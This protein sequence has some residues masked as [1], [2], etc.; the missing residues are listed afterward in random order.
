MWVVKLIHSSS[1]LSYSITNFIRIC[2]AAVESQLQTN[3][4]LFFSLLISLPI[5]HKSDVIIY[6]VHLY[7]LIILTQ[8]YRIL[9]G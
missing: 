7:H 2:V 1:L 6:I 9:A 5:H 8:R 4:S 3:R